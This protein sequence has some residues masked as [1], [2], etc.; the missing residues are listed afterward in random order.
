MPVLQADIDAYEAAREDLELRFWGKWV[1]VHDQQVITAF[2]AAC[3]AIK[4]ATTRFGTEPF[5]V[6]QVGAPLVDRSFYSCS[7][8][9]EL[10]ALDDVAGDTHF[11]PARGQLAPQTI[12]DQKVRRFMRDMAKG[13]A[14]PAVLLIRT[15][16][17]Y[18]GHRARYALLDGHHRWHA[19]RVL[20]YIKVPAVFVA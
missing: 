16:M 20:N 5:L 15:P 12:D 14:F 19:S 4:E 11:H 6:K 17:L 18:I 3:W 13:Q 9:H 7:A 1:Y 8:R 2:A 10:I